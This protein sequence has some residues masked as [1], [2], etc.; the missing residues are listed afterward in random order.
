VPFQ[1]DLAA[2][3]ERA[4]PRAD[5]TVEHLLP[6]IYREDRADRQGTLCF[7]DFGWDL[8]DILRETGFVDVELTL[9]TA[10]HYGYVGLQHVIVASRGTP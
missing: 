1:F 9:F 3:R 6:P 4:K 10:P 2:T 8:L 5:G 7:T